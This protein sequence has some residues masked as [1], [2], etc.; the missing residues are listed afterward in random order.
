[1]QGLLIYIALVLLYPVRYIWRFGHD[2]VLSN[3]LGWGIHRIESELHLLHIQQRDKAN[4]RS[5]KQVR[6][7]NKQVKSKRTQLQSLTSLQLGLS[8]VRR[9]SKTLKQAAKLA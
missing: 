5:G 7:M 1:M 3:L 6:R 2:W 9:S 8:A 4:R